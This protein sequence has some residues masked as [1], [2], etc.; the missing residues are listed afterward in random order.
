MTRGERA[1]A[2]AGAS[3]EPS[4]SGS[5]LPAP[6]AGSTTDRTTLIRRLEKR[7]REIASLQQLS[8][9]LSSAETIK[10]AQLPLVESQLLEKGDRALIQQFCDGCH[11]HNLV[12]IG[13]EQRAY[14]WEPANATKLGSR[15]P[16]RTAF[17]A[18]APDGWVLESISLI[19][20]ADGHSCGDWAHWF[21][22][23]VMAYMADDARVGTGSFPEFLSQ[24]LTDL[25]PLWGAQHGRLQSAGSGASPGSAATL[26]VSSCAVRH[27][28]ERCRG[29]S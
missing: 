7:L 2:A 12:L 8:R 23:R 22:C 29:V 18:A 21:R 27:R 13:P 20:Q 25:R 4:R 26:C 14:Y 6:P 1:A 28:R 3:V 16:I 15:S 17:V 10:V 11:W 5:T 19:A 9:P 24:G